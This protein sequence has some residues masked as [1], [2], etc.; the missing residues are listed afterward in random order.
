ML[1]FFFFSLP[2]CAGGAISVKTQL[3]R[4]PFENSELSDKARERQTHF[5]TRKP[6]DPI[7]RKIP[8]PPFFF[9]FDCSDCQA[10]CERFARAIALHVWNIKSTGMELRARGETC[11]SVIG[12]NKTNLLLENV[13]DLMQ[14]ARGNLSGDRIVSEKKNNAFRNVCGVDLLSTSKNT[15]QI[16]VRRRAWNNLNTFSACEVILH[17]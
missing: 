13:S 5:L 8:N 16:D 1:F 10:G 12:L 14:K 15:S 4:F 17:N 9:W 6:S 3:A 7:W 2:K 11:Q